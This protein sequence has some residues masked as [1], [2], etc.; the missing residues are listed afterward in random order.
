VRTPNPIRVWTY[1]R[2]SWVCR[3]GRRH[4][5]VPCCGGGNFA[6]PGEAADEGRRH[7]AS[8]HNNTREG[9]ARSGSG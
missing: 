8:R 7:L 3:H 5:D 1:W 9:V 6:T 2:W 4:S